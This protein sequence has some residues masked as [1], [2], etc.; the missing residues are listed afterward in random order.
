MI[1][2]PEGV[3]FIVKSEPL[4]EEEQKRVSEY[5]SQRKTELRK[6]QLPAKPAVSSSTRVISYSN[7]L[8]PED[9]EAD[10]GTRMVNRTNRNIYDKENRN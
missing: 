4:S 8:L 1:R 6:E 5:I 7:W 9:L 2:E 10:Y 3:D